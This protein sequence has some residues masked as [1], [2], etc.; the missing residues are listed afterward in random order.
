MFDWTGVQLSSDH[1]VNNMGPQRLLEPD[2]CSEL[3]KSLIQL[4]KQ[5]S[6]SYQKS[7][8]YF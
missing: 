4:T 5:I 8:V 1:I 7:Q 3:R 6:T 2:T